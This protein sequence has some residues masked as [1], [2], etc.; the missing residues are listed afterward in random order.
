LAADTDG[1]ALVPDVEPADPIVPF[2]PPVVDAV[3]PVAT[4]AGAA[5][6][7]RPRPDESV[8]VDALVLFVAAA[9]VLVEPADVPD[10]PPALPVCAPDSPRPRDER[11]EPS[12]VVDALV[13]L[14]A[15]P[16]AAVPP[17][18]WDD[19]PALLVPVPDGA[20]SLRFRGPGESAEFDPPVRQPPPDP[21]VA[22]P[23]PGWPADA[24]VRPDG[25]VPWESVD[26]EDVV[27]PVGGFI[28]D[29][30]EGESKRRP[31]PADC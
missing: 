13:L 17:P 19:P 28:P 3:W 6:P 24:S 12:V 15:A 8:P 25:V 21:P 14:T 23:L 4:D 18:G 16:D 30:A 31:V 11:E 9:V 27:F 10:V 20:G 5:S 22:P 2:T 26:A 29:P 1:T 7:R